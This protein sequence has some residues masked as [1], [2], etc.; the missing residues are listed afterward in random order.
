MRERGELDTAGG[1]VAPALPPVLT[2]HPWLSSESN[3][4]LKQTE[5]PRYKTNDTP[6][7]L[8]FNVFV[9]ELGE[10]LKDVITSVVIAFCLGEINA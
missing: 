5:E 9:T 6:E 4:H 3:S 8:V 2:S 7:H 10:T 1:G